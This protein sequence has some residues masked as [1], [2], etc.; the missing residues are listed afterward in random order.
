MH[1]T[2]YFEMQGKPS[3]FVATSEFVNAASHQA[4]MLG[5]EEVRRVFIPHPMQ[6]R[7]DEEMHAHAERFIDEILDTLMRPVPAAAGAAAG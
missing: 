6:D 3:V 5:L 1:D 7:T 2:I 4:E